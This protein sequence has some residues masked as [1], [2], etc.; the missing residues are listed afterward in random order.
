MAK[1]PVLLVIISALV[2]ALT[3]SAGSNFVGARSLI[4]QSTTGRM[5]VLGKDSQGRYRFL[6]D[7]VVSEAPPPPRG[8]SFGETMIGA[9]IVLAVCFQLCKLM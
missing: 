8:S 7:G 2:A 6:V 9:S 1:H 4:S 3:L 5:A